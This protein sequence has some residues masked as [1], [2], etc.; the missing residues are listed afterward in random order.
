MLESASTD[1]ERMEII[2]REIAERSSVKRK[3]YDG[4]PA[5]LVEYY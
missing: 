1:S 4:I 3:Q 2:N 5:C